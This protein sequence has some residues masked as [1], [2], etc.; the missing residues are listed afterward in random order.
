MTAP[1]YPYFS[2]TG[3]QNLVQGFVQANPDGRLT[4]GCYL[5]D[6]AAPEPS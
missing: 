3:A 1:D 5:Y 6:V 2:A 4:V